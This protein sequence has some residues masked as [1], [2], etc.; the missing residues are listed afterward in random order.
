[1]SS[2][3]LT[4]KIPTLVANELKN[5]SIVAMTL[6]TSLFVINQKWYQQENL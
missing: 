2:I 3:N 6:N 4:K 1:M 5:S